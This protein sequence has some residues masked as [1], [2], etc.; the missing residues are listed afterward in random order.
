MRALMGVA[1]GCFLAMTLWAPAARAQDIKQDIKD[2]RQDRRDVR[3]DR[4]D[5]RQDRR[6]LRKE[7]RDL[8]QG[9]HQR[10]SAK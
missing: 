7:M 10:G 2:L 8:R 1:A 3:K 4:Q 6:D 5:L 9:W